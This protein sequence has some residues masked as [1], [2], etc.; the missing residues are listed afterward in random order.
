MKQD[1]FDASMVKDL[2]ERLGMTQQEF[3]DAVTAGLRT[4][5][6]WESTDPKSP[7]KMSRSLR[8]NCLKLKRKA[9]RND[10]KFKICG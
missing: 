3:A 5:A 10:A 8:Q 9:D 4:V 6:G 2:R 1:Y 7:K